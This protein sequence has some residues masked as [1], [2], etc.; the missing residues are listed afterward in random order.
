MT[1]ALD[2]WEAARDFALTLPG[3]ELSTSYGKPAV[4]IAANG[5]PFLGTGRETDTS[6]VLHIDIA[7]AEMLMATGPETFW[8]TPHYEGHPAVLVRFDSPDPERVRDTIRL[9]HEQVAAMKPA[10]KRKR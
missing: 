5:R 3:T 6:F 7:T 9:A 2:S 1:G 8:Q 4:K 10:V